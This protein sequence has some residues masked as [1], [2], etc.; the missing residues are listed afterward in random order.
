MADP[1]QGAQPTAE[2]EFPPPGGRAEQRPRPRPGTG[3]RGRTAA[4]RPRTHPT[5]PP[6]SPAPPDTAGLQSGGPDSCSR[7][8]RE[9]EPH[10]GE[11]GHRRLLR[12][13]FPA[14]Q[15]R[16]PPAPAGPRPQRRARRAARRPAIRPAPTWPRSP[17]P[18]G[19]KA[20]PIPHPEYSR[21]PWNPGNSALGVRR[22]P[23]GAR[24]PPRGAR[25]HPVYLAGAPGRPPLGTRS[26]GPA[27]PP[28]GWGRAGCRSAGR[29]GCA[30]GRAGG[31]GGG[32]LTCA[33]A[34][35]GAVGGRGSGRAGE[36]TPEAQ[37]GGGNGSRPVVPPPPGEQRP[38]R[39]PGIS[40]VGALPTPHPSGRDPGTGADRGRGADPEASRPRQPLAA[41]PSPAEGKPP[42]VSAWRLRLSPAPL[43]PGE[44]GRG[45]AER[46]G[47]PRPPKT[48]WGT[49][50]GAR[51]RR[52]VPYLWPEWVAAGGRADGRGLSSL[53]AAAA[54]RLRLCP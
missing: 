31:R 7:W 15:G 30:E 53:W 45:D 49:R 21:A 12:S 14:P 33:T 29:G 26:P 6:A 38:G 8:G 24:S 35:R 9:P 25:P 54:A 34:T 23:P 27:Q 17:H 43:P 37:G 36:G 3:G 2:G 18:P 11:P 42:P 51:A 48:A 40:R 20:G 19:E 4:R 44:R 47:S 39:S 16:G 28:P 5:L 32:G 1:C 41:R 50:S 10:P 46:G 22:A 13:G 52:P